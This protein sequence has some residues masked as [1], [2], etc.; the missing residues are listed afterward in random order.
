[1]C[2]S[3]A[4]RVSTKREKREQKVGAEGCEDRITSEAR[5]KRREVGE[6]FWEEA[7]GN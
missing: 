3:C 7:E 1:M 4:E 6:N 2:C 5:I